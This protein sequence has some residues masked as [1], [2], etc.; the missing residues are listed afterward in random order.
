MDDSIPQFHLYT[1]TVEPKGVEKL[2]KGL[3]SEKAAGPDK[4][5]PS[6]LKELADVLCTPLAK[7]F[8]NSIDSGEVPKQ[9]R[10]AMVTPIFKKGDKHLASNYRPV[11]LTSI[12]CKLCEHLIAKNL[13]D[14]L[15]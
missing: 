13:M 9:W 5:S 3:K 6:I 7:L 10:E 12:C 14:H 2:L 4:I 8:Q 1:V 15:E 11:S